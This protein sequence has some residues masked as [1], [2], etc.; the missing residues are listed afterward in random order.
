MGAVETLRRVVGNL[1][2]S[3]QLTAQIVQGTANQ[4]RLLNDKLEALIQGLDN[5]SSLLNE[6]LEALIQGSDNQSSLLNEKLEVLIQG[7]DNQSSRL[8][9]KLEAL[10]QGSD[11]PSSLLNKQ[12]EALIQGSDNQSRLLNELVQ[13]L[14]H[15][16]KLLNPELGSIHQSLACVTQRNQAEVKHPGAPDYERMHLAVWGKNPGFLNDPRFR[17]AYRRG[18]NSGHSFNSIEGSDHEI[19]IEWSV[20]ICC[21]AAMQAARLPGDFVECG[22]NTGIT[23][24]AVCEYIDFNRTGKCFWLFDTFCGIP[25]EQMNEKE[26]ALDRQRYNSW[27]YSDCWEQTKAN[28]AA[29]PKASLIRGTVPPSLATVQIDKVCYLS[30]DMNIAYPERAAV[31]FFWPKLVP[32]AVVILDDYAWK[33]HEEQKRAMDEFATSQ[34]VSVLTLPTG[35]GML[36]K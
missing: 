31:E 23:S 17:S 28:F 9:E 36:I 27:W 10:I 5:Q 14:G 34:G 7:S 19:G 1:A 29:F 8:N 3:A 13:T 18:M 22:V 4:S 35:Q 16:S 11:I 20:Y 26:K 24:L 6:K 21:W 32:G 33:D 2:D 12:L 25:E 15:P 30:I